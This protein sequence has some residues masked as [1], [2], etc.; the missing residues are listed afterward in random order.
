MDVSTM[1]AC[2]AGDPLLDVA[3]VGADGLTAGSP[4]AHSCS[5]AGAAAISD[6]T[7]DSR[8][9]GEGSLFFCKGAAFREEFLASAVSAGAVAY[10]AE[11]PFPSAGVPGIVVSDVRRAMAVAACAFFDSPSRKLDVFAV[12]GTKG[13]TTV[14]FY[15]DA[16]LRGALGVRS[17]LITG[18][19]VD[20]GF[21]RRRATNTTPEALELQRTFARAV[22]AGCGTVV[23]E[24]S[25][26]GL[27]YG[28]TLGAEFAVG[29]FTNIGEDHISPIEHPTFED[30][31]ASKLKIFDQSRRAVVNLDMDR[32]DAVLRA[33]SRCERV[34]TYSM[35]G[36]SGADV[37]LVRGERVEPG[38]WSLEVAT[39]GGHL[40]ISFE[41]L[42]SFNVSN[43]LAA[44]CAATAADV[45]LDAGVGA[46]R[47]VRVPGRMER[48]DSPD[49]SVIGIVDYAHNEMS[50][51]ALLTCVREEFPGREVTV[52]FGSTGDRGIDR[53]AGLG[54][55]AGLLADRVILTEDDPGIVP[56]ADICREI[57]AAVAATGA[58]YRVIEDRGEAV[59]EAVA[60]AKAPAVVVLAG[61]GVETTIL[62]RRGPE[63]CPSDAERFCGEV[64]LPFDG[65]ALLGL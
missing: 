21:D 36:D 3:Y 44:L 1:C 62:R 54:R 11:R 27:K 64:G 56:V 63:P 32:A 29:M 19:L 6:L 20:D 50:M 37:R 45:D 10:V 51:R 8:S 35:R 15:L 24:A 39:P 5:S 49:G 34:L 53:R 59:H 42:G 4:D 26:Q 22:S 57:G 9:A 61:K 13:K 25:S 65:G 47:H 31:F 16:L 46:L 30:Y 41:A 48:Y 58:T 12:T 7:F 28:R 33:A 60:G 52:V 23:M 38:R 55:A 43:A 18:I 40:S 2:L 17:A 14:S